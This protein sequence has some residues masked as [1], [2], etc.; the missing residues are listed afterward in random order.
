M[1]RRNEAMQKLTDTV[2]RSD[3]PKK[4]IIKRT[5]ETVKKNKA[6]RKASQEAYDAAKAKGNTR[7][8]GGVGDLLR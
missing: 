4:G 2:L 8:G 1:A 7:G 6:D 3:P 5:I